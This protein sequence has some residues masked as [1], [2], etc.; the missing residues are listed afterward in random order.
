MNLASSLSLYAHTPL[1]DALRT[2]PSVARRFFNDKPFEDWRKVREA[3]MKMLGAIVERLNDV[4]RAS[5]I[6]A[7]AIAKTR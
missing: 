7:K 2:A 3:E 4:I 6:V 5:V 1:P